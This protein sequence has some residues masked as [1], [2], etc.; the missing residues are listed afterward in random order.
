MGANA[1]LSCKGVEWTVNSVTT[2]YPMDVCFSTSATANGETLGASY[3]Y[4]C[5]DTG[6]A[7][8]AI[9]GEADCQG[10]Y[11]EE[12]VAIFEGSQLGEDVTVEVAAYCNLPECEY[13]IEHA[14]TSVDF[15]CSDPE[16][17]LASY[18]EIPFIDGY[19]NTLTHEILGGLISIDFASF[20]WGCHDGEARREYF[21]GNGDCSGNS[22]ITIYD[23]A[24]EVNCNH[25]LGVAASAGFHL[26]CGTAAFQGSWSAAPKHHIYV[27]VFVV[28]FISSFVL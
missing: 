26:D 5:N 7:M 27:A 10:D 18:T 16:P 20:R 13:V 28:F 3:W 21:S 22:T 4:H 12:S 14:Y 11:W 25:S 24:V 15:D 1:D 8:V 6:S 19:C 9:Y 2:A 23:T 17:T